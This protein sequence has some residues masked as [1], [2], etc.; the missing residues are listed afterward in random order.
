MCFMRAG[1]G[2]GGRGIYV[3]IPRSPHPGCGKAHGSFT[4]KQ[5][6][7]F[8]ITVKQPFHFQTT[9]SLFKNLSRFTFLKPQPFHFAYYC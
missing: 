5:L 4:F 1:S 9:V 8:E 3:Y 2:L 6:F 7:H